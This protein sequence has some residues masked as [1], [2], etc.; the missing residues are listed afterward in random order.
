MRLCCRANGSIL[1]S[2][3]GCGFSLLGTSKVARELAPSRN[4]SSAILVRFGS[5]VGTPARATRARFETFDLFITSILD[6][7]S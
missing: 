3:I 7:N 2:E 1:V 4:F 6:D 5:L